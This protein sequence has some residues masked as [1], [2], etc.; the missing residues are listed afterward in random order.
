MISRCVFPC[1]DR[2]AMCPRVDASFVA[3][4]LYALDVRHSCA[5]FLRKFRRWPCGFTIRGKDLLTFCYERPYFDGRI[6]F[7]LWRLV[8]L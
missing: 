2:D 8:A 7:R 1:L 5:L 3:T 4:S 6:G